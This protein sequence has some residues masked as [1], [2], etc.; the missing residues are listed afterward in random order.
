M[1]TIRWVRRGSPVVRR[2]PTPGQAVGLVGCH[3]LPVKPV[4]LLDP[5][6][7]PGIPWRTPIRWLIMA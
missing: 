6:A 3:G 2:R 7:P 1:P 5:R 4:Q